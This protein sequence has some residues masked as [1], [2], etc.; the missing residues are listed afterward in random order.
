MAKTLSEK[1]EHLSYVVYSIIRVPKILFH[2]QKLI[3]EQLPEAAFLI[4]EQ[5]RDREVIII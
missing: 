2:M 5:L 3:F 1:N 4:Q